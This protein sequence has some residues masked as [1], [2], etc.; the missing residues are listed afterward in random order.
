V[1]ASREA[2]SITTP[3]PA[4]ARTS[5]FLEL[6]KPKLT[7][8]VLFTT[9]VGFCAGIPGS[10]PMLLLLHTLVGTAL[11]S[12]GASAFN[13]YSEQETD[14]LMKRTA[15]RPLVAGRLQSGQVLVF[16][17]LISIGGLVYLYVLVN[18][19]TSLLSAIIFACYLFLY[20]PLKTRTWLCTLVGAVPGALPVVMGWSAATGSISSG[21][22][23]LFAIVFCW[24]I[25][26]FYAIG[27]M[28]REEYAK[29]GLPVLSV[30]D[31][32]GKRTGR[33]AVAFI[34]AL[35]VISLLPC[36]AGMGGPAYAVGA[37][38]FG[39][40]FFACGLHFARL[41]DRLSARRLFLVSALYLPA[42]LIFLVF[43]KLIR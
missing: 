43:D 20:T 25:P 15:L 4:R 41:R 5:D 42:L 11:M 13:M 3:P 27:W 40:T 17:F 31:M 33:Q 2:A 36:L 35:I 18:H 1:K 6:T 16:A 23:I 26:H 29:A 28:Y 39:S 10:I 8:L 34:T 9:F 19:L 21:G 24:Q 38:L 7:L 22:W 14:A 32:S 37:I 30:I 12:G